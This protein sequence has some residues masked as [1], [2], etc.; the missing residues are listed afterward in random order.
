LIRPA[1]GNKC[2]VAMAITGFTT[3]LLRAQEA[4]P[5]AIL[6]KKVAVGG[7][8]IETGATD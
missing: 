8:F 2:L 4:G 5:M 1:I 6:A 3:L 7:C